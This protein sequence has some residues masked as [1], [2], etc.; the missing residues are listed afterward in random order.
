MNLRRR[1]S[2]LTAFVPL[3]AL[4]AFTACAST[5]PRARSAIFPAE[6]LTDASTIRLRCEDPV[7]VIA[8]RALCVLKDLPRQPATQR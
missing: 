1:S 4:A 5:A 3:A 7:E 2:S 8:G 6:A